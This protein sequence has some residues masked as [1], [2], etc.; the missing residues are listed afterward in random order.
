LRNLTKRYPGVV[1]VDGVSL[2]F[3]AG[4]VHGLVGE[5]GAGKSTLIKIL[6]GAVL[7]DRGTVTLDG[8]ALPLGNV[9]ASYQRGLAFIH[10]ELS[11][12]PYFD[13]AE[14]IYLGHTYPH[15]PWGTVDR[16]RLRRQAQRLLHELGAALPVDQPVQR[17]APGQQT[18]VAL[19]RAFAWLAAQRQT[20]PDHPSIIVMDEPTAT[21]TTQEIDQLF[22]AIRRLREGGATVIY[23]SHRLDEIF[24]ITDRVTVMRNGQV[25]HTGPTA[26][27]DRSALIGLMTGRTAPAP[28]TP[29]QAQPANRAPLLTARAVSGP[30]VTDISFTLHEG[31]ILG[32]AGLVGAGRSELLHLLYGAAQPTAGAIEWQGQPLR[33]TSP[34]T[35][36]RRGIGH[37][38]EE[39]R[40][41]GLLLKRAI[42]ENITLAHLRHFAW[43][44]LL[45]QRRREQQA[46]QAQRQTLGI[47]TG[48][49]RQ[50][51]GQLSGGNQ[52]KVLFARSL[53]G[54]AHGH[55]LRLLLLDEPTRGIDVG[56][57]EEIYAIIRAQAAAGVGVVVVSSELPELL[58]LSNR[59]LVLREGRQMALVN[60]AEVDQ[61]RVLEYCYGV[62]A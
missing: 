27:I 31:D 36:L 39:R 56:A 24:T 4:E 14:N 19:A 62:S 49:L 1:A 50:P 7:P 23:V 41:Q 25:V 59:I 40:S 46:A 52:Q 55:P 61:Q 51:V 15:T 11:L 18:M 57:K 30:G 6:A 20:H 47:K 34:A 28:T 17:L 48:D 45:L 44:G 37:L 10:Q 32:V 54:A 22:A 43:G 35:A 26:A 53:V 38:P 29:R 60:T 5:N 9:H 3:A 16:R 21:L 33:L 2:E 12:V 58:T 42:V 13:A 8:Q